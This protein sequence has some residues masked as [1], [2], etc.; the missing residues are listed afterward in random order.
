MNS[1]SNI[2]CGHLNAITP[3]YDFDISVHALGSSMPPAIYKDKT[4]IR[5]LTLSNNKEVVV[6]IKSVGKLNVPLLKLEIL[7]DRDY[8]TEDINEVKQTLEWMFDFKMDLKPFYD[9]LRF[10]DSKI[11]AISQKLKG[12]KIMTEPNP[13]E[14]LV[15]CICFQMISFPAAMKIVKTLVNNFG[16]ASK[17]D[18]KLYIFPS[19]DELIDGLNREKGMLNKQK[20]QCLCEISKI[21]REHELDLNYL[22]KMSNEE[23]IEYCVPL[24]E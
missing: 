7:F 19:P 3:P 4:Y 15:K 20:I 10:K 8:S 24:K 11:Y 1:K 22:R 18:P 17:I 9:N 23:I 13:F 5:A 14:V 6:K 12:L 16:H 21:A 2:W